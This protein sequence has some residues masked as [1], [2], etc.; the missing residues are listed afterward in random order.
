MHGVAI[1]SHVGL[2]VPAGSCLFTCVAHICDSIV[3]AALSHHVT[4]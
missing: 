1:L 2:L 4:L 3:A